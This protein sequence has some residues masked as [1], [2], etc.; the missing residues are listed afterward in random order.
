MSPSPAPFLSSCKYFPFILSKSCLGGCDFPQ[1]IRIFCLAAVLMAF[2]G[3]KRYRE[4]LLSKLVVLISISIRWAFSSRIGQILLQSMF[5]L[6]NSEL[7]VKPVGPVC[8]G[9][10]IHWG[11]KSRL[12]ASLPALVFGYVTLLAGNEPWWGQN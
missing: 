2:R 10:S 9:Q 8:W 6:C 7:P 5:L 4:L 12:C 11:P 1:N 3:G